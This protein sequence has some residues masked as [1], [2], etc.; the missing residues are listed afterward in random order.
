MACLDT[1]RGQLETR[2]LAALQATTSYSLAGN[3]LILLDN[4]GQ[5]LAKLDSSK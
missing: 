4:R 2:F 3:E 5:T 1:G